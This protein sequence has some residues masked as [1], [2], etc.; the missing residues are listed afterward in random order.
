MAVEPGGTETSV[1][2]YKQCVLFYEEQ[3]DS[4]VPSCWCLLLLPIHPAEL[5]FH[6]YESSLLDSALACLSHSD[7][8]SSLLGDPGEWSPVL[9]RSGLT[10]GV[11]DYL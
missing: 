10:T 3:G 6:L 4:D 9:S 1:Y 11:M 8:I 7:F 5:A 2:K